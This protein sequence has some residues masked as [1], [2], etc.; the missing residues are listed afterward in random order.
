M[1]GLFSKL[2]NNETKD[3]P[4]EIPSDYAKEKFHMIVEDVFTVIGKGTIATGRIVSGEVHVGDYI[5]INGGQRTAEVMGIEM[6]R[7][8]LDYAQAGDNCG[9]LLKGISHDEI[10]SGDYLTK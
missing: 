5:I 7:K 10:N 4:Q 8:Q 6:F 2:F 9:I 3:T 1:M